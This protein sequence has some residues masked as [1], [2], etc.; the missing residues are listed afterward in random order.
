MRRSVLGVEFDNFDM[1]GFIKSIEESMQNGEKFRIA[2]SNPEFVYE[3]NR[4]SR[5]ANY[6]HSCKYIM[7]DG[8]GILWAYKLLHG[9][10]LPERVSGTEFRPYFCELAS[11]KGY[12]LFFLGA[13]EGVAEKAKRELQM[14][15]PDLRV[16]GTM[17]GYFKDSDEVVSEIN[18]SGAD[19][20]MVCLGNP[21]QEEWIEDNFDRLDVTLAFGNGG[22]LD[23]WSGKTNRGPWLIIKLKIEWLFRLWQDPSLKRLRREL[24]LFV[25]AWKVLVEKLKGQ[26]SGRNYD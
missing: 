22:A 8:V 26:P 13:E 19:I 24:R 6:L 4:N 21:I 9:Q 14:T 25:F 12:K 11:R 20:L 16:V 18:R 10:A 23:F 2:F 5:L 3:A 7:A 15:F 17:H 1:S